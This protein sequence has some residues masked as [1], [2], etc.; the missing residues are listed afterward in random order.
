MLPTLIHCYHDSRLLGFALEPGAG[1][2]LR[3]S[4]AP[5]WNPTGPNE[6]VLTFGGIENHREVVG[7]FQRLPSSSHSATLVD[8]IDV[9]AQAKG[10]WVIDLVGHGAVTVHT[11]KRPREL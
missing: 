5:A 1:L 9:Q 8:I 7:F 10:Q 3:V 2:V 4:L 11:P 6:V